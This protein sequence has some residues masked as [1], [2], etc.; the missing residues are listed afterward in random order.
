MA[1]TSSG[2]SAEDERRGR[3]AYEAYVR[4]AW[5]PER[6]ERALILPWDDLEGVEKRGWIAA[7][8]A[9]LPS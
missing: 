5:P 3:A 2:A 7:A 4:A 1:D 6:D 8:K 9:G